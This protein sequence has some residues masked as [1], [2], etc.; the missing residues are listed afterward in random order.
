MVFHVIILLYLF[1]SLAG[2]KTARNLEDGLFATQ[3][4]KSY[5]C[6]SPDVINLYNS[7]KER[8]VLARMKDVRLQVYDVHNGKF[9]PCKY[10]VHEFIY[11]LNRNL[12]LVDSVRSIHSKGDKVRRKQG[13][14]FE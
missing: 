13:G 9:S 6:P 8:V 11:F 10:S 14:E 4:G 3:Y 5:F 12:S 2:K 7:K 1:C